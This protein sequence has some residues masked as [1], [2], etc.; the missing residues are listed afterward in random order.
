M[1]SSLKAILF[2]SIPT[3]LFIFLF[4]TPIAR[5]FYMRGAFGERELSETVWAMS[6]YCVGIPFFCSVKILASAFHSRKD[7]KTPLKISLFCIFLNIMLN[8]VLMFKMK[9]GG[10]ALATSI[11]SVANCAIMMKILKIRDSNLKYSGLFSEI[12]RIASAAIISSA[13]AIVCYNKVLTNMNISSVFVAPD[14]MPLIISATI[15]SSVF[16]I[17]LHILGSK[18]PDNLFQTAKSM[19]IKNNLNS[20]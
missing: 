5:L 13:T 8:L 15:F 16:I 2:L 3:T 9:Q 7:M 11:S 18:T 1:L 12:V 6:F 14:L 10:I 17:M 20:K 19:L 4:K